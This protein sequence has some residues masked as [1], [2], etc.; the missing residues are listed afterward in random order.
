MDGPFARVF[1]HALDKCGDVGPESGVNL[2][3]NVAVYDLNPGRALG[4]VLR[5]EGNVVP[6]IKGD[7]VDLE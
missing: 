5:A 7:D 4:Q 1:G 6:G 3:K 2:V